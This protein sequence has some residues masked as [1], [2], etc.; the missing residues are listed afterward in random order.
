[1]KYRFKILVLIICC[2]VFN[3]LI[4]YLLEGK[5]FQ[6]FFWYLSPVFIII[7]T[8]FLSSI[9]ALIVS[10]LIKGQFVKRYF[11]KMFFWVIILFTVLLQIYHFTENYESLYTYRQENIKHNEKYKLFY[12][13]P[14]D[15]F[16][17]LA[18]KAIEEK[19]KMLVIIESIE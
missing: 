16:V 10:S 12:N 8:L 17:T 2:F 18:I 4:S 13:N 9:V 15:A 5:S 11:I 19:Q 7:E 1:M 14:N 3:V 6:F